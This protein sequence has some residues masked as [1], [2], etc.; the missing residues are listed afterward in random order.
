VE[1][2]DI[3]VNHSCP[4]ALTSRRSLSFEVTARSTKNRLRWRRAASSL[5][6]LDPSEGTVAGN[7]SSTV[8]V[9]DIVLSNTVT[10]EILDAQTVVLAF[11]LRHY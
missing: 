6:V 2:T 8:L 9:T 3:A 10:I 5:D 7:G 4:V 11:T 1:L